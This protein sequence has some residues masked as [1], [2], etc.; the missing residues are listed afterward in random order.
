MASFDESDDLAR[1]YDAFTG[2]A[3]DAMGALYTR[4]P[5]AMGPSG[6]KMDVRGGTKA[7]PR[8][9]FDPMRKR[10]KEALKARRE[11]GARRRGSGLT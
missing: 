9:N 8:F 4:G 2:L 1:G 10:K 3:M 11:G 7:P 6:F 5:A